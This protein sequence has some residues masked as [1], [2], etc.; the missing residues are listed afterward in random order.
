MRSRR[1]FLG[2][3]GSVLAAG[4]AIAVLSPTAAAATS[5]QAAGLVPQAEVDEF[6]GEPL[7]AGV[8][9]QQGGV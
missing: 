2:L 6:T 7:N 1:G 3:S 8:S 9:C 4:A 5:N